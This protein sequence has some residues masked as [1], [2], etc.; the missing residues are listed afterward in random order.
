MLDTSSGDTDAIVAEAEDI[1]SS[2]VTGMVS[3]ASRDTEKDGI[4]I[5]KDHFIGFTDKTI[6]FDSTDKNEAAL[7]LAEKNEAGSHDIILLIYGNEATPEEANNLATELSARYRRTETI[8]L[9]GGQNVY[10]YILIFE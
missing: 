4:Q 5:T 8:P 10:D 6:Y 1:M 7:A 9:F 2:V 3:R